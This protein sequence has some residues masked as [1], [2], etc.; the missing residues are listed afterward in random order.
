[1]RKKLIICSLL[2][3]F[4][5]LMLPAGSA[6]EAKITKPC[7]DTI[8]AASIDV[9]REKNTDGPFPQC[10]LI[11]LVIMLLKLLRWGE[12]F[13]ILGILLLIRILR[14]QNTTALTC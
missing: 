12:I 5:V 7:L 10:I 1:M 11:T 8:Q 14:N 9:I 4:L 13:L 3:V 6:A 2:A